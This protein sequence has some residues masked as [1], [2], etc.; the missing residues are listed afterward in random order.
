M[1]S[2]SRRVLH[3]LLSHAL[4]AGNVRAEQAL[5]GINDAYELQFRKVM[6]LGQPLCAHE[7][8]GLALFRLVEYVCH[9]ALTL[10]AVAVDTRDRVPG[11]PLAQRVFEPFCA[12]T[13]WPY[14]LAALAAGRI[15]RAHQAAMVTT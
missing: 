9:R 13:K 7:N 5:I 4:G 10:G 11:K 8:V 15:E 6:P 12:L 1:A 14:R 2:G 3:D